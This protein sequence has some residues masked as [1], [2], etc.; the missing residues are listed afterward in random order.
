MLPILENLYDAGLIVR[1][2]GF[3]EP[4]SLDLIYGIKKLEVFEAKIN[5]IATVVEQANVNSWFASKT[6]ILSNVNHPTEKTIQKL[7]KT[8]VGMYG[9]DQ[10]FIKLK[11]AKRHSLPTCY[12]SLLFNEWIGKKVNM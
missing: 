8:G 4:K 10:D 2:N 6:F 7:E 12:I 1:K 9:L 5:N 3:Y 11:D